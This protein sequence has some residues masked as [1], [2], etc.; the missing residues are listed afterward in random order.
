MDWEF[1]FTDHPGMDR[2]HATRSGLIRLGL[3]LA[4]A[5][6]CLL[7]PGTARAA[8]AVPAPT[9]PWSAHTWEDP[10]LPMIRRIDHY[11]QEFQVD[12]VTM[13]WRY[14]VVPSEE[15]RQTVVCQLLAY[16]ELS[17]LDPRTRLRVEIVRHAD[18]LLGRLDEIRSFT[19]FDGMLAYSLLGAY[20]ITHEQR[21]LDAGSLM[22]NDLLAIPTSQCVLNGGLMVAMATAEYWRLTGDVQ[23][24]Q[25]THD[26]VAQLVPY[27]NADGSFPHWCWG[28]RDIHYTG[29]MATELIHIGRLVDDSHIE[30]FLS[31]MTTFLEGRIAPG[32]RAIYEEP[33]PGVPDCMLYYYSRATGCD[34]DLDSRGWTTEPAYCALLFDRQGSP[35]YQ[36]VMAFLDSLEDG[37][38]I[39]DLYGYW[40]PPSDP[41]YPWTIAD[42]SVVCMSIDLWVLSTAVADRVERG[43]PVDLA[44]DDLIDTTTTPQDPPV[45]FETR[46]LAVE[47]NPA[48][49]GCVLRFSLAAPRQGSLT[50]FDASGRRVRTLESGDFARGTHAPRWDGRDDAGRTMPEGIYFAHLRLDH[51]GQTRRITLLR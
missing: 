6:G 25:K 20:E 12:G 26:I 15:I 24:E 43:V 27:Q 36:P 35:K 18:F 39:A 29:W 51:D 44:L 13:D 46:P 50:M 17:R 28:S 2:P 4:V 47:P 45:L 16:V 41:E 32:G 7:P 31:A 14:S 48:P 49:G 34:Y 8:S 10:L 22:M 9:L 19:P 37:G 42:T 38:T 33:C 3:T 11:L 40:P 5:A 21:F 1:D 23:A 30:P